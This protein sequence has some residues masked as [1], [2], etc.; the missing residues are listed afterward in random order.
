M[1]D[2][3]IVT[4]LN[5]GD[6]GKG[7]VANAVGTSNSLYV[8]SS[9]SCQRAHTVCHNG[10][11]VVFR[12]FGSGTVKGSATYFGRKFYINP[13]MFRKEYENLVSIGIFPKVYCHVDCTIVTVLDMFA[14]IMKEQ[15]RG[16][17]RKS[18]TGCGVWET[19]LRKTRLKNQGKDPNLIPE[20]IEYYKK[21]LSGIKNPLIE[22]FLNGK[23]LR[24]NI[25]SDEK[26]F[27]DHVTFIRSD[28]VER[29]LFHSYSPIIFEN[30]QGLLLDDTFSN[31]TEHNT[32]AYVGTMQP[33]IEILRNFD[34]DEP[35][36]IESL[37]VTRT[38][39]TRHGNGQIG[40]VTNCETEKS[41]INSKMF[42]NTNVYNGN[43]GNLRYGRITL[44]EV[45]QAAA[46]VQ[47]DFEK[48]KC[49]T[50]GDIKSSIVITHT[51]EYWN[52]NL[53]QTFEKGV[54][55]NIYL[56]DNESTISLKE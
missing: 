24:Y 33:L 25:G 13:A 51:N 17:R 42:D 7:L 50:N 32:P 29:E 4:G 20:I 5:Y 18:S 1:T 34:M 54:V 45:E 21:E 10:K 46:R 56:S 36:S 48:L 31:D 12:H 2:I 44:D 43:Q 19:Y 30:G 49:L 27:F 11:R 39:Y 26:F 47:S 40:V 16:D 37:Y 3:K 53:L 15:T 38:Y 41:N 52:D 22:Q 55:D 9:S 23:G 6:E 35:L 28:K 8:L 14:N